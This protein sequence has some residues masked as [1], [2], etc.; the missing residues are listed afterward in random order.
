MSELAEQT[1]KEVRAFCVEGYALYDRTYY[2]LALRK[3]YQAWTLIPKPQTDYKE[4]GWVL[5]AIGDCYFCSE[6][7]EQGKEAL[8]SALHCPDMIDNPFVH[9][10]LGQCL[11]ELGIKNTACT[12]LGIAYDRGGRKMFEH[13]APKYLIAARQPGSV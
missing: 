13:E 4:S 1:L 2:R 5:T 6:Q 9:L 12:H 7:Y 8:S 10:R 3:F 11:F